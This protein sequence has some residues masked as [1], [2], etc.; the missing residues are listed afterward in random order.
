VA[1]DPQ[2]VRTFESG[3]QWVRRILT[4]AIEQAN[5]DLK[6]EDV[7][8]QLDVNLDPRSTNHAHADFWLSELG[9]GHRAVGPKYSVN[10]VGGQIVWLYK[11]GAPGRVLGTVG[12]CGPDD[13]Q[14]LLRDAAEEFGT[15]IGQRTRPE[16]A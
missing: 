9:D 8:I 12:R 13:I 14:A 4:P 2:T 11:A 6:P 16:H 10:V 5:T 15:I 3:A 7:G 1:D